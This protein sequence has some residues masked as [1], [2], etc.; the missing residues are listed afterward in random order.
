MTFWQKEK[1]ITL[2]VSKCSLWGRW[3]CYSGFKDHHL[4][5]VPRMR[6]AKT[7][8]AISKSVEYYKV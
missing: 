6:L 4:A 7:D 3:S 2:G 8:S 5:R 1:S